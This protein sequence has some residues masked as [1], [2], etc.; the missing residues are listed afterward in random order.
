MNHIEEIVTQKVHLLTSKI[1]HSLTSLLTNLFPQ[2]M[3]HNILTMEFVGIK[4][5]NNKL[6]GVALSGGGISS[7][8]EELNEGGGPYKVK[9]EG[10]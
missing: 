2:D 6:K 8:L 7:S 9:P 1:V 3:I 5:I 4:Y 10:S